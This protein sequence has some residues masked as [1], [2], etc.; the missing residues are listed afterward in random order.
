VLLAGGVLEVV[1]GLVMWSLSGLVLRA[2]ARAC[3]CVRVRACVSACVRACVE[4]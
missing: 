3:A 1:D 2:C 4:G